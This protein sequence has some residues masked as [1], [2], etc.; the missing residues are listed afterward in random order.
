M[1]KIYGKGIRT[2]LVIIS[3]RTGRLLNF[4]LPT[5]P[6]DFG[7]NREGQS[8]IEGWGPTEILPGAIGPS[9]WLHSLL[10]AG[11]VRK[12]TRGEGGG[13]SATKVTT[14]LTHARQEC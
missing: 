13:R 8:G 1:Y 12:Q 11:Q 2:I 7:Q 9:D 10:P 4:M 3:C 5:S 14:L 6:T